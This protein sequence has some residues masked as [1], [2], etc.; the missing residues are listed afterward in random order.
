MFDDFSFL[1]LPSVA[2][3]QSTQAERNKE[4]N[5]PSHHASNR[6]HSSCWEVFA[7]AFFPHVFLPL[8]PSARKSAHRSIRPIVRTFSWLPISRERGLAT[9]HDETITCSSPLTQPV[10]A[11]N[12]NAMLIMLSSVA[13][14]VLVHTSSKAPCII[15][16]HRRASHVM[17]TYS[18]SRFFS[19]WSQTPPSPT[20]VP[21]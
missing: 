4:T 12:Q 20:T 16:K 18:S 10:E 21:D 5:S 14:N 3:K 9:P 6:K 1:L 19:L 15:P 11:E 17:S 2:N 8:S 13:T 7:P